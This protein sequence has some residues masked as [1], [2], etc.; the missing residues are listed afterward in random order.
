MLGI[1]AQDTLLGTYC[2]N[3]KEKTVCAC[4]DFTEN[5]KL[6][7]DFCS[8]K[9]TI[10]D[11]E[12]NGN[13][14]E[15]SEILET[16]EKQQF[17]DPIL[18]LKHFWKMFIVDA[19]L[20]NFDRHNGNWGFLY[21]SVTQTSEIAPIFDCGSCL[22]PQADDETM[23]KVIANKE[24]MNARIYQFQTSAIKLN[25]KKINYYD[26]LMKTDNEDCLNALEEIYSA[27]DIPGIMDFI[28]NIPYISDLQKDFYQLYIEK[29]YKKIINMA[30]EHIHEQ[31]EI[32]INDLI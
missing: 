15:L 5:G 20:G 13:G 27:I 25:D 23:K 11:S 21:D 2:I 6:L 26:F 28:E 14:T 31:K 8:I 19:L 16:V 12:K 32:Q 7:Y 9:N 29:R 3:G 18:L 22:L 24:A 30:Y 17:V 1:K 10:I 4:R